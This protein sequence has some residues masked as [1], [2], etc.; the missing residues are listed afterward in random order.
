M[1]DNEMAK[2]SIEWVHRVKE[3]THAPYTKQTIQHFNS[4]INQIFGNECLT[5]TNDFILRT[6]V[7][8]TFP[9]SS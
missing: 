6:A 2:L 8:L 3:C 4:G 1:G 5:I 7:L 9:E